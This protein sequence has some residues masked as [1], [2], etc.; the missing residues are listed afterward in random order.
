LTNQE[1]LHLQYALKQRAQELGWQKED[2]EIIDT[3]LGLSGS[4]AVHRAGFKEILAKVTL[5]EVGIILSYDVPRLSR[6]CSD[7]YPLLDICAYKNT[8]I[9]DCDGVYDPSTANGRLLLGLKGQISEMELYTIRI[10][11]RAGLLNKASRGELALKLPIGLTR[12][13]NAIVYKDANLQVQHNIELI[14]KTFLQLKSASKVLRFFNQQNLFI[15]RHD[16]FGDLV[17]KKPSV[18][19]ILS[20]LQNPAYAGAF[21]YG[22]SKSIRK[23]LSPADSVQ[24]RLPMQE[25]KIIVKDKYPSYI[26]WQTFEK[27]QLMLK[28]NHAEYD[29]N[30]TRGIPRPGKALLHGIVY[31]GECSHKMV[32]QYKAGTRYLC[33]FLRQ[34]YGVPVCQYIPAD[35]IDDYVV[36]AFFQALS[37]LELDIY[38]QAISAKKETDNKINRAHAQE[39]ERLRFQAA[40]A[41]R[42]FNKVDPENRLVASELERRWE[43][44]LRALKTAE[45]NIAAQERQNNVVCFSLTAELKAA[46]STIGQKLPQIWDKDILSQ[47]T[48][49]ALLRALIDKV[50]IHRTSGDMVETRIVWKGGLTTTVL[51]PVKVKSYAALSGFS[52]MEKIILNLTSENKS[53]EQIAQYLTEKGY[54][55]AMQPYV[56]INT[57]KTIRLKHKL[58][59]K[60]SQSHPRSIKGFLTIPQLAQVL[61]FPR[62]WFYDRINN[63]S[64]IISKDPSTSLFLFPDNPTTLEQL[65]ALKNGSLY[66]LHFS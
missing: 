18:A 8:L 3:D 25:W 21:V 15:P 54:R 28:D 58:F 55:S 26:D 59:I 17:W 41:Q 5:G 19:A 2:I 12:N 53:D 1:S 36:E 30:K 63:G 24:K 14:F 11:L 7:F 50:V 44:S 61:N 16:N 48:K 35:P 42:Q 65:Q 6:N 66:N 40:F 31:C 20:T 62:H 43:E 47:Q 9:A 45:E 10:R 22:R 13:E 39:L 4:A 51:V 23:S 57:V 32:V 46:F 37:P 52:E 60:R 56:L 29:R 49:K 34:Q 38:S 64:I 33:N 27:I